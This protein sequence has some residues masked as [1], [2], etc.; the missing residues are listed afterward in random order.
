MFSMIR[1]L[2]LGGKRDRGL[3]IFMRWGLDGAILLF[4]VRILDGI[5]GQERERNN[6]INDVLRV[7]SLIYKKEIFVGFFLL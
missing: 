2:R 5:R 7:L 3:N 1:I 6:L 4:W